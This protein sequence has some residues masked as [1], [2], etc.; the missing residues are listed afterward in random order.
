MTGLTAITPTGALAPYVAMIWDCQMEVQAFGLERILPKAGASLI[1]NL[2]EDETRSYRNEGQWRCQRRSGSVLVG[3]GTRHF[4]ID[5]AEQCDVI[6]V[7]FHPGGARSIFNVPLD[8]FRDADT[9]LDDLAPSDARR[10]R[11]QLLE[12]GSASRRIAVLHRWLLDRLND[13]VLPTVVIHA[14]KRLQCAPRT[15]SVADMAGY[16]GL[17]VRRLSALFRENI[18]VGPKRFLRLQR[19]GDV[20]AGAHSRNT[21]NWS[22]LAAD[23]G[24][25]DQSHLVHEFREFSGLAPGTWLTS[26]GEYPRHVPIEAVLSNT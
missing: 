18:G 6:G 22:A 20:I 7:E 5:T 17:S 11:E 2:A 12:A 13:T 26:V 1:I 16:A 3:P 14:L 15:Q 19:F 4:I 24:Y 9:D 10:L 8:Q 21:I 25:H 23:C